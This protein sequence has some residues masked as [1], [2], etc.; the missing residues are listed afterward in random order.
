MGHL[1][2]IQGT[3]G[4]SLKEHMDILPLAMELITIDCDVP[5]PFGGCDNLA[6]KEFNKDKLKQ[7][8]IELG[9]NHLLIQLDLI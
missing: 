3:R 6:M 5:I 9:F 1:D 4:A 8:F 2:E 7:I